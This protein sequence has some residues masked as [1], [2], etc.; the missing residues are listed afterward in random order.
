MLEV[1]NIHLQ[2]GGIKILTD[3]SFTITPGEVVGLIGPNGAGKSSFFNVLTGVFPVK[4]GAIYFKNENI[5]G[6]P[7][8]KIYNRGIARTFQDGK[9]MPQ[10]TVQENLELACKY[11]ESLFLGKIFSQHTKISKE[12]REHIEKIGALLKQV[13]IK[14]KRYHHAQDVSYGQGKLLEILKV[15]LSDSDVILLDEPFSGLFPEMI[16]LIT[17]LIRNLVAQN[18]TIIFVEHNMKLVE[19]ICDR[20]IVLDAG[21]KIAD[22][23]FGEVKK[24]KEVIEAYLGS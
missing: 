12:R 6:L 3:L 16:H 21:K 2:L 22:G 7:S 8:H 24:N 23:S 20:V 14:N 4:S 5:T 9:N 17:S 10:M 11:H 13:S 1:K 19:E 18:K 15:I